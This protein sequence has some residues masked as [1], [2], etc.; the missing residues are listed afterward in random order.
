M[1]FNVRAYVSLTRPL[2]ALL[3]ALSVLLGA[4]L[5]GS[6]ENLAAVTFACVSGALIMAGGNVVNDYY[7][8][9]IDAINKPH[10]PLPAGQVSLTEA[11]R[12]A[13]ILFTLGLFLS[14]FITWMS[15]GVAFGVSAGLYFYAFRLKRCVL[16]GNV[17][18]SAFSALAF[19]YGG[20]A[21]GGWSGAVI[22]GVF[23]FLFHLG[24]EILKDVE[25]FEADRANNA[26]TLP[27]VHGKR[28]ALLLATVVLG[29]LIVLTIL[30]YIRGVYSKAYL[31]VV[32]PGVDFVLIGC[33]F[34]VW[35][36]PVPDMLRR[37]SMILKADMLV[38][39]LAIWVGSLSCS[40]SL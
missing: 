28:R 12:F 25:D 20:L 39:L 18:V 19:V 11:I 38:G 23:A 22:P 29:I 7:D 36:D 1:S 9:E 30:P 16:W 4:A 21:A 2:N 14:I 6:V 5:S 17:A 13:I 10:R 27:V 31:A 8:V 24:R 35:R 34:F 33:L 26:R 32:V 3:A 37:I 15:F 40:F